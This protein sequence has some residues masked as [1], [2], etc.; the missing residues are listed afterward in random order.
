M[1][2][3]VSGDDF[4]DP[5]IEFFIKFAA[6]EMI[7]KYGAILFYIRN[8]GQFQN[9]AMNIIRNLPTNTKL[10]TPFVA[11]KYSNKPCYNNP[12]VHSFNEKKLPG[13]DPHK[14][15]IYICLKLATA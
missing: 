3:L 2:V 1:V 8:C 7:G 6:V 15:D 9:S 5:R 11:E 10:Y 12:A 14:K 13:Y 4:S